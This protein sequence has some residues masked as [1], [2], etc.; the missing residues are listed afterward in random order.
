[1]KEAALLLRSQSGHLYKPRMLKKSIYQFIDHRKGRIVLD[2][3]YKPQWSQKQSHI[4][5]L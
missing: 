3:S 5:Q 4:I 1:M 2:L